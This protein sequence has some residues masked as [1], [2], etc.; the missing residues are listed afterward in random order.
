M[1]TNHLKITDNFL[2]KTLR[3][4]VRR[5]TTWYYLKYRHYYDNVEVIHVLVKHQNIICYS[6]YVLK[7]FEM[8]FARENQLKKTNHQKDKKEWKY[9][10]LWT[11]R[12]PLP[13]EDECSQCSWTQIVR[14]VFFKWLGRRIGIFSLKVILQWVHKLRSCLSETSIILLT[15]IYRNHVTQDHQAAWWTQNS[16]ALNL[17][18]LLHT[19]TEAPSVT[20]TGSSSL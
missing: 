2:S 20:S 18:N 17:R 3:T 13:I 6:Q 8:K 7:A 19:S 16:L 14:S 11:I 1:K 5:F 4:K 9:K 10:K 12:A 15:T